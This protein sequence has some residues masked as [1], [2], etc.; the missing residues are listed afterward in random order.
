MRERTEDMMIP[1]SKNASLQ[2]IR[3]EVDLAWLAGIIDGEGSFNFSFRKNNNGASYLETKVRISNT[4]VRMI[5]KIA[6]IYERE[7]IVFFYTINKRERYNPKWKDQLHIEMSGQGSIKKLLG[8]LIPYLVNK[9]KLAEIIIEMVNLRESLPA[10]G[11][12]RRLNYVEDNRFKDLMTKY[13][14]EKSFYINPSE[15]KR[16]AGEIVSW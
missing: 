10:N 16:R 4:D 7:N 5:K 12:R 3:R 9:Q 1:K 2:S 8:M 15:T 13:E 6:E 14:K 11:S